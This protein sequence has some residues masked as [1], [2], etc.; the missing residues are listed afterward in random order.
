QLIVKGIILEP[1]GKLLTPDRIQALMIKYNESVQKSYRMS[2]TINQLKS[3]ILTLTMKDQISESKL[4]F[5]EQLDEIVTNTIKNA[6]IGSTVLV[7]TKNYLLLVLSQL[8]SNCECNDITKKTYVVNAI[9]FSIKC[10]I[11]CKLC[12]AMIENNNENIDIRFS[13]AV[14]AA[15]FAGG[16]TYHALQT[17]M[18]NT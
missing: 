11:T 12:G 15:S 8:C 3:K 18:D 2:K 17:D 5:K 7:D 4:D 9:G 6:E 10:C 16:L 1:Q 14:A 13:K